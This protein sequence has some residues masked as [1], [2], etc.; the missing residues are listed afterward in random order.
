[1]VTEQEYFNEYVEESD[2]NAESIKYKKSL[3][4]RHWMELWQE[5]QL[6]SQEKGQ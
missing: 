1:M 6:V 3:S 5:C 2:V 4:S